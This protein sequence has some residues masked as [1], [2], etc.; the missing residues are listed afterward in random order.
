MSSYRLSFITPLFSKGSYDDIPEVR[1]PSIRGQLHWWF[2]ALG[3]SHRAEKSIFGSVHGGAAASKVVVRVNNLGGEKG[4][5]ATLPHKRGGLASPKFAYKPGTTCDLHITFRLGGLDSHLGEAFERT[6]EAWLLLGTLGLRGTRAAGSFAWNPLSMGAAT[7]PQNIAE[8][9]AR[10]AMVLQAAPLECHLIDQAFNSAE[11]ARRIVSDTIGG[12]EDKQG[13]SELA[14]IR[15]PLGRVFGERK[16]SPLRF[17][18]VRLGTQF[19][20]VAVW[21]GRSAVTGNKTGDLGAAIELLRT[22]SKKIGSL[23]A[24]A[25]AH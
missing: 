6:V 25:F 16:T 22:K 21:D 9:R 10:C 12:R 8:Y 15:Y 24:G 1:P 19:H 7:P 17:R 3:G 11:E 20:I 5:V 13:A 2:R 18:I 23:L 4:E 14:S